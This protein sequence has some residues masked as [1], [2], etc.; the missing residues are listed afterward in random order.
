[1]TVFDRISRLGIV[2][3]VI[4]QNVD[5]ALPLAD[6]LLAGGL[7][8][9][10]ITFRT[11]V[12]AEVIRV[13]TRERSELLVG[14]GTLLTAANVDAAVASGAA[15]GVSP[16][17]NPQTVNHAQQVDLPFIP[18]V[19]TP[20]EIEIALSLGCHFLKVFP[21]EVLGGVAMLDAL[22]G[23]FKHTG[24]RFMPSGG[25]TS[26]NFGPY[27]QLG[28]VAAAGGTWFARPEDLAAGN[29]S[30]IQQRARSAVEII[31]EIRRNYTQR[32]K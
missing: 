25:V 32:L 2:P 1:M 13:L 23:P 9:I 27:L 28:C 11:A 7:P 12:A 6:A 21:A 4:I 19:A 24:V 16:G 18:G 22:W 29:W 10:E 5:H 15:F 31:T 3:V 26:A 8:I 17:L 20:S 14:A 30:E